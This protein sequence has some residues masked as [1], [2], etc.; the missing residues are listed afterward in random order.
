MVLHV[1]AAPDAAISP[2]PYVTH[3]ELGFDETK[4]HTSGDWKKG[5]GMAK[6]RGRTLDCW[7]RKNIRN[8]MFK[9]SK[10]L[11]ASMGVHEIL[12]QKRALSTQ[13]FNYY[14]H[15]KKGGHPCN[16]NPKPGATLQ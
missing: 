10:T 6:V 13:M 5:E 1:H 7:T 14:A 8:V 15:A 12:K 3:P 9:K 16:P 4:H 2:A 11:K